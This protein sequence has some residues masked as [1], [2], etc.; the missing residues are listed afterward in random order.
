MDGCYTT[1]SRTRSTS[2][3][4]GKAKEELA[5]CSCSSRRRGD[6]VLGQMEMW[7]HEKTYYHKWKEGEGGKREGRGGIVP[8]HDAHMLHA[9]MVVVWWW[10]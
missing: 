7:M 10:R 9:R 2:S 5:A 6:T 1:T 3:L 4:V 8:S